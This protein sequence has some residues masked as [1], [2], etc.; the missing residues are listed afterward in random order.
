MNVPPWGWLALAAV[1]FLP[2]GG[3]EAMPP[4]VRAR[5]PQAG[6]LRMRQATRR[7]VYHTTGRSLPRLVAERTRLEPGTRAFDDA[8]VAWYRSSGQLYYGNYL[9]GTSGTIYELAAPDA[10]T[11]HAASLSTDEVQQAPPAWWRARWPNLRHPTDLLE[12]SPHINVSS[13]G[14]DLVP[15]PRHRELATIHQPATMAATVALGRALAGTYGLSL[16]RAHHL[17]HEDLDPWSRSN[18]GQPWDPGWRYDDFIKSL[19]G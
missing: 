7:I 13:L 15:D 11:L 8:V 12:G 16:T 5:L 4:I 17:G 3:G 1:A 2:Q 14:I 6:G 9:V 18:P 19:E 10:W